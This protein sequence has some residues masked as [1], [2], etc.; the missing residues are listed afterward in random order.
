MKVL[1]T[2]AAEKS[3]ISATV[4]E[5]TL[6]P[7]ITE[8]TST[9]A[10]TIP[11]K[12]SIAP[13]NPRGGTR[14]VR[15][16]YDAMGRMCQAPE[17]AAIAGMDVV[18]KANVTKAV[19]E[20]RCMKSSFQRCGLILVHNG[21]APASATSHNLGQEPAHAL[22][23]CDLEEFAMRRAVAAFLLFGVGLSLSGCIW[24]GPPPPRDA[25]WCYYHPHKCPP[26][27]P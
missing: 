20:K 5:F 7:H 21:A 9:F 22:L 14:P 6:G 16:S 1:L 13:E 11:P 18:A 24:W 4:V 23:C 26:P 15:A 3:G 27:P 25:R 19:R 2:I 12:Y 10:N 8:T 17:P